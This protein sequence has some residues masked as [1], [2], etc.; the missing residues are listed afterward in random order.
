MSDPFEPDSAKDVLDSIARRIPGFGGY[1]EK[2]ERRAS[3]LKARRWLA[4][5]LDRVKPKLD[6]YTRRLTGQGRLDDLA[7]CDTLR[8]RIELL[9]S[10]LRGAAAGY[11]GFFDAN[12]IDEDRL[13]DILEYDLSIVDQADKATAALEKLDTDDADFMEADKEMQ[14]LELRF[15][16]RAALLSDG[17][18]GL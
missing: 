13:D 6:A 9:I 17:R 5:Q 12:A 4:D 10:R 7:A 2:E 15:A 14:Q 18:D 16:E 3:D 1:L 11:S 8:N